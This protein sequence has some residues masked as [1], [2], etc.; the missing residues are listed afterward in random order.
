MK[1]IKKQY[2][3]CAVTL[4]VG[5][6]PRDVYQQ[7]FNAGANRYLLR[8]ET[9]DEEHYGKLHPAGISLA[10]RKQCLWDLKEIGFQVISK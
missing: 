5:E 7:Y 4:S 10:Q 2:P 9:A 1:E 3:D 8:H 6:R